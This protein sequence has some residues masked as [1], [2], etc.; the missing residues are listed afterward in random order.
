[1][2]KRKRDATKYG[3]LPP[4]WREKIESA[5]EAAGEPEYLDIGDISTF[6]EVFLFDRAQ[7]DAG[8]R[9]YMRDAVEQERRELLKG[10][11]AELPGTLILSVTVVAPGVRVR[12]P[13]WVAVLTP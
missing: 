2:K 7:E 13:G 4:A 8:Y 3:V 1:M 5:R 12:Q 11:E 9:Y 10:A 6:D